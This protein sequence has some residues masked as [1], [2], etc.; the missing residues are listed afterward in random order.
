M[1]RTMLL[2]RSAIGLALTLGL[3]GG[4]LAPALAKEKAPA[5]A[6]AGNN[7]KEFAAAAQPL[8]KSLQEV[9]PLK[10]KLDAAV[11]ADKPAAQAAITAA[12]AAIDPQLA[13][14]EAQ[15]KTPKDRFVYGQFALNVGG[16]KDDLKLRQKGLQAMFDS[17]LIPPEKQVEYS[18]YLGNFAY[19][20]KDYAAAV[21]A[22]TRAVQGNTQDEYAA[23][24]LAESL[25]ALGKPQEGLEALKNAIAVRK[26]AG[27]VAPTGWYNR[28][29]SIAY[30][31]KL[32][33]QG[34]DWSL[35]LVE[36]DP[37]PL[38]W[39][40]AGQSIR[41]LG[42]FTAQE[43]VD[44]GRL[45]MRTGAFKNEKK[46]VSREY[47]E[48]IQ[49]L[50]PR[51]LPGEVIRVADAG[52]ASGMLSANDLFVKDSMS[53]A[54]GRIASDQASLT[55]LE[56]DARAANGT[57]VTA[58]S[59]ADAY[60][61]YSNWAKAAEMYQIALGKPG[62]DTPRALTRLGIAQVEL[63]QYAQAQATFAKIDGSRKP[64]AQL[65][66]IY[67]AGKAKGG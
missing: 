53:Q 54:K 23:Q 65:W 49:S 11:A 50:D 14:A 48:Y 6:A 66:S 61:S 41:D 16:L 43:S 46:F 4:A 64:L 36:A 3:A 24:Q 8:Q 25:V 29:L 52:I 30:K 34:F 22:L 56:R 45:F 19:V 44:L 67:T 47:V 26:A 28:A 31:N 2:T 32:R 21:T 62:V 38:N 12:M 17:G 1:I 18:V 5:A 58:M 13:A 42:N 59:A 60:L 57:A 7:S 15:I 33:D 10:A 51:R 55:G 40:A 20:N 9:Q 27:G 63:G 35:A 39:L 37:S